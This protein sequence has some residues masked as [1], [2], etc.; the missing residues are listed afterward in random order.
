MHVNEN[1]LSFL[2]EPPRRLTRTRV[3][4]GR[5]KLVRLVTHNPAP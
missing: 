5:S 4:R 3:T 1:R 2:A